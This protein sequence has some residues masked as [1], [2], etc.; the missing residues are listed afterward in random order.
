MTSARRLRVMT[1]VGTRPE[2]IKLSR[3]IPALDREFDHLL[4]HSGQNFSDGLRDVFFRDLG[5]RDPDR[6]LELAAASAAATIARVIEASDGLFSELRPDALLLYG[7]TNT[8]LAALPAKRRRIPIFHMEAGNR[9]FDARIP[10]EVNRKVVDHL[11]DVNLTVSEHA[12]RH[13]LAEGFAA[14]RIYCVGSSMPEV[15]H[16]YRDRIEASTVLA[17]LGVEPARYLVVSVHRE[18]NVDDP[19]RLA[20]LMGTLEDVARRHSMPMIVSTHPRTRKRLD[21]LMA[22]PSPWLRFLDPFGFF[23]WIRLQEASF[24]VL[25]DSGTLT[26]E[27][28]H[29]GFPAVM[30]RDAHERPEGIEA[31]VTVMAGIESA[32]VL[33]AIDLV[34]QRRPPRPVAPDGEAVRVSDKVARIVLGYTDLVRRVVWHG[35]DPLP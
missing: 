3:V 31:G 14:D 26:E 19:V 29:L 7:D 18:E 28:T 2:L 20:R 22:D 35:E 23:D 16:H 33:A 12:R 21:A 9:A 10:E 34:V 15:L 17:R 27:A 32:R 8:C 13:L 4:I 1:I 24:C 30:L 11:A 6:R 25:S 5:I